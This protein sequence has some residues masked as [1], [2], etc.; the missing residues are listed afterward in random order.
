MRRSFCPLF[1]TQSDSC[2]DRTPRASSPLSVG[3]FRGDRPRLG[4]KTAP[5]RDPVLH[6]IALTAT[7][8]LQNDGGGGDAE[9]RKSAL[10]WNRYVEVQRLAAQM[11]AKRRLGQLR[12][13]HFP[14]EDEEEQSVLEPWKASTAEESDCSAGE[15]KGVPEASRKLI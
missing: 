3:E 10:P 11:E 9:G 2:G 5:W 13:W 12:P 4:R 7:S 15:V 8:H 6:L 14:D 1:L